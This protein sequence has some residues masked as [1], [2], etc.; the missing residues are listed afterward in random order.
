[1]TF[2]SALLH[3]P[4]SSKHGWKFLQ[5]IVA[6]GTYIE[7]LQ[8]QNTWSTSIVGSGESVGNYP[9]LMKVERLCS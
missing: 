6:V 4:N 1:M 3:S 5:S 7:I 8:Q 2:L 9:Y